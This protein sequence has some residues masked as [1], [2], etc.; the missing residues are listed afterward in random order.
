MKE[1]RIPEAAGGDKTLL[2]GRTAPVA[3]AQNVTTP[4]ATSTPTPS[5]TGGSN[6]SDPGAWTETGT[7]LG[8]GSTIN[9]RFILEE[10]IGQGGMGTVFKARDIRKEE[11]QDRQPYVAIK[12]LNEDFKRHPQSLR[13]LQRE[14]RKAQKLAHPNIVTVFDFDRDGANVYMVME[15]LEG[16]PLD[17]LIKR[18]QGLGLGAKEAIRIMRGTC[19]AMDYAH[20]QGIVHADFKPANTFL[21]RS[22][23]VKVFDFGIAHVV[24]LKELPD[25]DKT[26][27]DPGTLGA[28]TPAYAGCEVI[29]GDDPDPR[30]DV[31]AIACV[32]YELITGKHPFNGLSATQAEKAGL[33]PRQPEGLSSR[34]WRCLRRGLSFRR[35]GRPKSAMGLFEGVRPLRASPA[36]FVTGGLAAIAAVALAGMLIS[37]QIDK[38]HERRIVKILASADA[39]RIEPELRDLRA[40]EPT[41]RASLLLHEDAREGLI[42]YLESRVNAFVDAGKG[43]YD[44]PR[45]E[46]VMRELEEFIPDSQAVRDV[47]DRL[48]ARK[49]EEIKRQSDAFD[50]YL[51]RGWLIPAQNRENIGSVLAIIR[52]IDPQ[53]VLLHDPRLPGAFAEDSRQALQRGEPVLATALVTAGLVFAPHDAALIDL[54]DQAQRAL[55][56]WKAQSRKAVLE[57]SVRA[58]ASAHEGL[59]TV[60]NQGQE[61]DELRA[62]DPQDPALA[63]LQQHI[64]LALDEQIAARIGQ[65]QFDQAQGLLAHY[66]DLVSAS[67]VDTKRQELL[68]AQRKAD[69]QPAVTLP[70]VAGNSAAAAG[71]TER[72]VT[73][74]EWRAQLA[75]GLSQPTLSLEQARTLGTAIEGLTL[76]HDHEVLATKRKLTA[77]LAHSAAVIKSSQGID[78]ALTFT[79]G[80]YALFPESPALKK[81]LVDLLVAAAQRLSTQR[82]AS[83][84]SVKSSI[85]TLLAHPTL[86]NP[87]DGNLKHQLRLLAVY[88]EETDPYIAEVKARASWLYVTEAGK[89]RNAGRLTEAS[90]M[91]DRSREYASDSAERTVEEALLADARTRQDLGEREH[92]RAAYLSSL[93]Q[94]LLIQAQANDVTAAETS[95]RVL[96]ESLPANDRFM[97]QEGPG[98]IAQ[99]YGRLAW[100]AARDGQFQSALDL[101][102][103]GRAVAPELREIVAAQA[104]YSRYQALDEYLTRDPAP[105]AHRVRGEIAA[106]SAQD[107]KS[108][109]VVV[110]ILARDLA[111][112]MHAT[113]DP[114]LASRLLHAGR[115]IFGGES[116]FRGN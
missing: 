30:D 99:A 29:E 112:R 68:S 104:R 8:V 26:L 16:E 13:A 111:S 45:A 96:G 47:R 91:L 53:S 17:R 36:I 75:E 2:R 4:R 85:E 42:R 28:L 107:S 48:T 32:T 67:Y 73:D 34:Q 90:W 71:E 82:N 65:R 79:K 108:T 44:Y 87:W 49:S 3:P 56:A 93:K 23:T 5:T 61:I 78:A 70:Q 43:R 84:T 31:Y 59:A 94:K 109:K 64:Q 15:L 102:A 80:A 95:L 74:E 89:L 22:G 9:N 33:T 62:I 19:R 97:T 41:E 20:E 101:V 6:W 21:T 58:L 114:E 115:E 1:F 116:L 92:D 24:K 66:A 103:R 10:L 83:I 27:F 81:T 46:Q 72:A 55:T 86:D 63:Q 113:D 18:T 38:Y 50:L 88:V 39:S 57:Q 40:L 105:D 7:P 52:E 69:V 12:L 106:L 98:A 100:G 110:P 11:A 54:S 77:R 25:G 14:S 51:Q 35:D 37:G 76:H 60:E